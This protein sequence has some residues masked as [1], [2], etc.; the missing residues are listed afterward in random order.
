[1]A[2]GAGDGGGWGGGVG[3]GAAEVFDAAVEGEREFGFGEGELDLGGLVVVAALGVVAP[4][5]VGVGDVVGGAALE[6]GDDIGGLYL[7]N[8]V[9]AAL[10]EVPVIEVCLECF[11]FGG[12]DDFVGFRASCG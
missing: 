12:V 4:E 9:G 2:G 11:I 1:M 10:A 5:E 7:E 3:F 8:A 6:V